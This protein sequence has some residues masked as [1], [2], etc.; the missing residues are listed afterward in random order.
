MANLKRSDISL[1][2]KFVAWPEGFGYVLKFSSRTFAEFFEDEFNIDIEDDR[3]FD[4]GD[5]KR[6]RLISFCLKE[7][8]I[9]VVKVLRSIFD[10]RKSLAKGRMKKP[11]DGLESK[12]EEL[13]VRVQTFA[14]VPKTDAFYNYETD[15]TLDELIQDLERTLAANKPAVALDH[16][17]TYCTKKFAYLLSLRGIAC[18]QNDSLN[19]R[20]GKYRKVLI[21]EQDFQDITD[22]S[23]KSAI[24]IFEKFNFVRNN[25]SLAHD[26]TILS[27]DE[28]RFIYDTIVAILRFVRALEAGKFEEVNTIKSYR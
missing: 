3:Y 13:I 12:F 6:N 26:N 1:I 14:D 17:H 23:M 28:A 22:I 7:P 16:L 5:S 8:E 4:R 9:I 24:S 19:G 18:T 21:V 20:F 27:H 25:K 2:E 11:E 10:E 15:E